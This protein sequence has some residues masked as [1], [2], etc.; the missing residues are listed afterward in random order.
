MP[1]YFSVRFELSKGP[2]AIHDIYDALVR[3]GLSFK[4]GYWGCENETFEE[5]KRWNQEKLDADF[6]L[7]YT[8]HHSHDFKQM[9]FELDDYSEVRVFVLN[10]KTEATFSILLIIPEEDFLEYEKNGEKYTVIRLHEKMER[11]IEFAKRVWID[12]DVLTIQTE[13]EC[14]EDRPTKHADLDD[15]CPPQTEPFSIIPRNKFS[16]KWN[17]AN[18]EIDRDGILLVNDKAWYYEAWY[19]IWEK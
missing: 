5:I 1:A 12:S 19:C 15:S 11:I 9:Q 7:G 8:E 6:E 3:S 17:F 16:T 14:S 4:N 18:E 10:I 13:W 2:T